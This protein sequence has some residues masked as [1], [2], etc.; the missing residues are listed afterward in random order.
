VL[1]QTVDPL[2]G[3]RLGQRQELFV[4]F[5]P[6]DPDVHGGTFDARIPRLGCL[7]TCVARGGSKN[8]VGIALHNT[9]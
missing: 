9:N 2:A 3:G 7:K 6:A 4:L 1:L 5:R 8:K